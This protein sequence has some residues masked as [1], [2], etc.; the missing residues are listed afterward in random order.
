MQWNSIAILVGAC[1]SIAGGIAS[2][3]YLPAALRRSRLPRPT[4]HLTTTVRLESVGQLSAGA[5]MWAGGALAQV[6]VVVNDL[7]RSAPLLAITLPAAA[8][9]FLVCGVALGRLSM[10]LQ[11][12]L[13]SGRDGNGAQA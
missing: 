11:L 6:G 7:H 12:H 5:L 1:V 2:I 13:E 8:L 10:R 4:T 3:L 9:V